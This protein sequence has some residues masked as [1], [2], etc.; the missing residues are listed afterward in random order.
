[1]LDCRR[2]IYLSYP[3]A[4]LCVST[5]LGAKVTLITDGI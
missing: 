2:H 5:L 4:Q 1:L 3:A